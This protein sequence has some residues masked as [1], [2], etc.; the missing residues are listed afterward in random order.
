MITIA[1]P[2]Y[3]FV[4]G[5]SNGQRFAR[6]IKDFA[7]CSLLVNRPRLEALVCKGVTDDSGVNDVV[8]AMTNCGTTAL[9]VL[10]AGAGDVDTARSIHV[11]LATPYKIGMAIAWLNQIGDDLGAWVTWKAG[12]AIPVG[13][14]CY[15]GTGNNL[16]VEW[17]TD[18]PDEHAG[19]GRPN[20]AITV[21]SS[22]MSTNNGRPLDKYLDPDKIPLPEATAPDDPMPAA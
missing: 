11:L 6:I 12:M 17:K 4:I 14:L 13:A 5:E 8:T 3:D 20:N 2:H 15:Y 19:G 22:D 9:G 16:H 21:G 10:A 1:L 18:E 7:G